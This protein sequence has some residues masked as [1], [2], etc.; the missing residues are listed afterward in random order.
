VAAE[1]IG[2]KAAAVLSMAVA[3]AEVAPQPRRHQVG[4]P[5]MAPA[6]V[7]LVVLIILQV[8]V[9]VVQIDGLWVA[10]VLAGLLLVAQAVMEQHH[11]HLVERVAVAA[12]VVL[13][14]LQVMA[15]MVARL[16]EVAAAVV[17]LL[18][19]IQRLLDLEKA[20]LAEQA[21]R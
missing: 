14:Q 19:V 2:N 9:L 20:V 1:H 16:V 13:V 10:V 4:V 3:Q 18:T 12:V 5:F 7:V 21:V 17:Q 6:G 15:V 11:Q 8:A